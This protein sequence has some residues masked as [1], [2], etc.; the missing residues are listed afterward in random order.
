V[1]RL[2]ALWHVAACVYRALR[3]VAFHVEVLPWRKRRFYLRIARL[4][5][6][7]AVGRK[8]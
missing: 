6:R 8:Q 5:W 2:R 4:W 7:K 3:P 1:R